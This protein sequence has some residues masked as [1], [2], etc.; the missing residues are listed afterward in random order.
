METVGTKASRHPQGKSSVFSFSYTVT[1][2]LSPSLSKVIQSPS[3][4]DI[5]M[6]SRVLPGQVWLSHVVGGPTVPSVQTGSVQP[7]SE[8]LEEEGLTCHLAHSAWPT[9]RTSS[10]SCLFPWEGIVTSVSQVPHTSHLS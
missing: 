5:C 6:L 8:K 2:T 1:A 10:T 9:G 7:Q 4:Y 3:G